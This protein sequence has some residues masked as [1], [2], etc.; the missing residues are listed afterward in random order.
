MSS[1]VEEVLTR[2]ILKKHIP[3]IESMVAKLD[4]NSENQMKWR[5]LLDII[6]SDIPP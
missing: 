4:G 2:D 5:K 3:Y 6:N 1:I